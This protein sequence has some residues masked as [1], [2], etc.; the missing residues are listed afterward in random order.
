MRD[1]ILRIMRSD[2]W[3]L[4]VLAWLQYCGGCTGFSTLSTTGL[5]AAPTFP[6]IRA[7]SQQVVEETEETGVVSVVRCC[8]PSVLYVTSSTRRMSLG[9]GSGFLVSE[10]GYVVTNF[11]VIST[12]YRMNTAAATA[13][14]RLS[15]WFST[16]R[17]KT[18][19]SIPMEVANVT[20]KFY[21]SSRTW[22]AKIVDVRPDIDV[23]VL[24]IVRNEREDDD[25]FPP[26][27]PWG[28]SA[29][30][31]VGQTV[32]AIGNPFGF[33]DRT[34]TTGIVSALNR[35]LPVSFGSTLSNCIQ[36][37]AAINPGSSGGPLLDIKGRVI[38][39][40]TATLDTASRSTGI[41]FAVPVDPVK[42]AT[43]EI[44]RTDRI[45]MGGDR[46]VP[47]SGYLGVEL[48]PDSFPNS[49]LPTIAKTKSS[50]SAAALSSF[51][52]AL[53]LK[54]QSNSPAAIGGINPFSITSA[55]NKSYNSDANSISAATAPVI[56]G[57]KIIAICGRPMK[58]H[59]DVEEDMKTRRKGE[60]IDLTLESL[61]D[62]SQRVIYITL[63]QR[64]SNHVK[65]NE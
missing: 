32:I 30:L 20:V 23:A 10:D 50:P 52:S 41:G 5:R 34:V 42:K 19:I 2:Y 44:I 12:A 63:A 26:A 46:A 59:L 11:H 58:T 21:D 57:D 56:R 22:E 15:S 55:N 7:S 61:Q 4:L 16:S 49:L 27:L 29:F 39:I 64:Q 62:G 53:V 40:N 51:G 28:S 54:V 31:N 43:E 25:S 33:L 38:G 9:A 3:F 36:T 35:N 1:I 45:A 65:P 60:Q 14:R 18:L 47:G 8:A 37:D 17:N 6:G 13:Y 24:R 48:A